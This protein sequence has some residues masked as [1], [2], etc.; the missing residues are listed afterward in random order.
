MGLFKK[1]KL[2]LEILDE[3]EQAEKEARRE[4]IKD[5]LHLCARHQQEAKHS[6]YAEHN[7]DYCKLE[8]QLEAAYQF[9][10]LLRNMQSKRSR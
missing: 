7:C 1:A 5:N 4:A 6:H 9:N 2:L 8:K 3:R 10:V